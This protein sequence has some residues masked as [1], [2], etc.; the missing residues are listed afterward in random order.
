MN[1]ALTC[2]K[3]AGDSLGLGWG[4]TVLGFIA[5]VLIP[6]PFYIAR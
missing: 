3:T 1:I 4:S 6:A 2:A 5:L